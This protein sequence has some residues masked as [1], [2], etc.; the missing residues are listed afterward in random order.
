MLLI[1]LPSPNIVDWR[2]AARCLNA[3]N[4]LIVKSFEARRDCRVVCVIPGTSGYELLSASDETGLETRATFVSD[5][6]YSVTVS[7]LTHQS[8]SGDSDSWKP[9]DQTTTEAIKQ[10]TSEQT[11]YALIGRNGLVGHI[12]KSHAFCT[13]Q[14][15]SFFLADLVQLHKT[16]DT[17]IASSRSGF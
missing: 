13:A 12:G 10:L 14:D 2:R 9:S 15:D 6:D 7:Y 11:T 16:L 1:I 5:L 8:G 17:L 3:R 4:S